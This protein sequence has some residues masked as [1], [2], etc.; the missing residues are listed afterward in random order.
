MPTHNSNSANDDSRVLLLAVDDKNAKTLP[1]SVDFGRI[2]PTRQSYL[3]DQANRY[4]SAADTDGDNRN[5]RVLDY[6]S[7]GGIVTHLAARKD[8]N[9]LEKAFVWSSVANQKG[10]ANNFTNKFEN[11]K[12]DIKLDGSKPIIWDEQFNGLRRWNTPNH[13][14]VGFLDGYHGFG[15]PGESLAYLGKEEANR[16][17]KE[18]ESGFEANPGDEQASIRMVQ[19]FR[20]YNT[21]KW[22]NKFDAFAKE[23]TVQILRDTSDITDISNRFNGFGGAEPR[24][25]QTRGLLPEQEAA[26][27][28]ADGKLPPLL[29]QA[30]AALQ[31]AEP[32]RP[33]DAQAQDT[34]QLALVLAETAQRAELPQIHSVLVNREEGH[35]FVSSARMDDP[36]ARIAKV[37]LGQAV[38]TDAR[39]DD[40]RVQALAAATEANDPS[41][42]A[43]SRETTGLVRG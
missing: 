12:Y 17:I 18:H 34:K 9:D 11:A 4:I 19:A 3:E 7:I 15:K 6:N 43:P 38:A 35:A 36:A 26:G 31:K 42:V 14:V 16:K 5:R 37:E 24:K 28:T 41:P 10:D 1:A 13:S 8:L 21:A 29:Q 30:T 25:G 33:G 39:S 27:V 32:Q 20:A 40:A 2:P 22:G 23:W